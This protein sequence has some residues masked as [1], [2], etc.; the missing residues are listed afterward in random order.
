MQISM[1]TNEKIPI[2][3]IQQKNMHKAAVLTELFF[4]YADKSLPYAKDAEI[5]KQF[6]YIKKTRKYA[7][8]FFLLESNKFIVFTLSVFV[9]PN[10]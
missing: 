4:T 7:V 10:S 6:G 2:Q 3:F 8:A 5:V 9:S 1:E